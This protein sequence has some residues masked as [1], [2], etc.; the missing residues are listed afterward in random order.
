[1]HTPQL[2]KREMPVCLDSQLPKTET[3]M[4][5]WVEIVL[6]FGDFDSANCWHH[7]PSI[8][9]E[10]DITSIVTIDGEVRNGFQQE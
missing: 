5:D 10:E 7:L 4:I 9:V 1:M 2:Q 3:S 8:V 6:A